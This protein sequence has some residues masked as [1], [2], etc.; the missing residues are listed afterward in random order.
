MPPLPPSS[1]SRRVVPDTHWRDTLLAVGVGAAVL[2]LIVYAVLSFS[3]QSGSTGQA[4][5]VILSKQFVA[6]PEERI[7]VGRD[8]LNT[9][10]IDGEY[11]FQV[12]V[13]RE[14]DRVYKVLVNKTDYETRREGERFLFFTR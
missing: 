7:T 14:H 11:S 1:S 2:G 8:G 9:R 12:R 3:A 13:P 5:G 6:Q 4:E 10:H